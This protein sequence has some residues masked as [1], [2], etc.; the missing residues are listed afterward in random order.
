MRPLALT[1]YICIWEV[2][3]LNNWSIDKYKPPH[4]KLTV[5]ITL[6]INGSNNVEDGLF[7]NIY[8]QV[9]LFVHLN[10]NHSAELLKCPHK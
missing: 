6:K 8:F 1:E 4:A 9:Q 10:V 3:Q 2:G 7:Y 5:E